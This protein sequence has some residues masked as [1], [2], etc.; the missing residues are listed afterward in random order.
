LLLR[1]PSNAWRLPFWRAVFPTRDFRVLHLLRDAAESIQ[2]LCDGWNYPF[3]FQTFP[4]D[5]PLRIRG[6]TDRG[7]RTDAI[8]KRH[9]LNFSVDRTL[10]DRILVDK[11]P[12]SLVDACGHQW[13]SAHERI[14]GDAEGLGLPRA[15]VRFTALRDQPLRWFREVCTTLDLEDSPSGV[16][17]A[18]AFS[19]RRVMTTAAVVGTTSHERWRSSPYAREIRRVISSDPFPDL[20]RRLA[21][22]S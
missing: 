18:H 14:I 19:S 5:E 22:H 13:R 11:E 1:D 12:S 6:Y 16:E 3:G 4:S 20:I 8:W 21:A 9:R 7:P 17:F 10:S 2:G 15:L